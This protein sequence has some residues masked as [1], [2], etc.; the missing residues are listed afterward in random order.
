FVNMLVMRHFP[1]S[2]QRFHDFLPGV[3][4]TTLAAF[5]NQDYQFEDLV[6]LVVKEKDP[7]R[8][9]LFDVSL[10]FQNME[11]PAMEIPGLKLVPFEY[12]R[13]TSR[14]DLSFVIYPVEEETGCLV[15]Y[16][17]ALFK[18]QTVERLT[19]YFKQVVISVLHQPGISLQAI[20][21]LPGEEK[22]Q[23]LFD[24]N[25]T[26]RDYPRDKTIQRSFEEQVSKAPDRIAIS[27]M[28][29]GDFGGSLI[30]EQRTEGLSNAGGDGGI[31]PFREG[32]LSTAKEERWGVSQSRKQDI[33]LTYRQLNEKAGQLAYLLK[34]KGVGTDTVVAVEV[35]RPFEMIAGI[36]AILKA[37][38]AYLPIDP[39]YPEARKQHMLK[40][41]G[42]KIYLTP[43]AFNN[44]PKGTDS[45]NN[46]QLTINHSQLTSASLAYIIYTSG[47]T[48][49][50]KGVM[51]EHFNVVR[52]VKSCTFIDFHNRQRLLL[53]GA[54]GFDITTFEIWAPLLNGLSLYLVDRDVIMDLEKLKAAVV[55]NSISVLH[56]IPGLFY[57]LLEHDPPTFA[58]L[59]YLLVGGDLVR[60]EPVNHLR[61]RYPDLKILH[62]YGPTENTTFSTVLPVAGDYPGRIPIGKPI[63]NSSVFI[64]DKNGGL[65]AV[66]I[67]GELCTG[68]DGVTRGYLN[69][70]ELTAEKFVNMSY[71][72][73]PSY[74]IYKTGDL[75]RWLEDGN[76]EFLGRIDH[77]VKI[78]GYRVETGE[79]QACLEQH[80]AIADAAVLARQNRAGEQYLCAYVVAGQEPEDT[81]NTIDTGALR[82]YLSG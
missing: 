54:P 81:G 77:Q 73:Y 76:I 48:G 17:K 11:I 71:R 12:S 19:G 41:S 37:G 25:D 31:L 58:S 64:L 3:R 51:V 5:D 70:P 16:S 61:N 75:A 42:A 30:K 69:N 47:S 74:K 44:R 59:E 24:F 62:C 82:D 49:K 10:A 29:H 32:T 9:P 56:F 33:H 50:P 35:E 80:E 23:V 78:R 26:A 57:Q 79:I 45:I 6:D 53:T 67:I 2:N 39:G 38:G 43:E 36:L 55:K 52:L 22:R 27:G 7:G 72:S 60:P 15:E 18:D 63:Q 46:Y 68:G 28:P 21:I 8:N 66:G 20:D 4:K 34:E 14:F 65:Q 1:I 40:D 13:K